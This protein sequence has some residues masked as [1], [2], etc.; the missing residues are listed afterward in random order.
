MQCDILAG[1]LKHRATS[2]SNHFLLPYENPAAR[3]E[4]DD[5]PHDLLQGHKFKHIYSARLA[6]KALA[7]DT[8]L[9]CFPQFRNEFFKHSHRYL[10]RLLPR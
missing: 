1:R 5:P 7:P 9:P 8:S 4:V 2:T 10:D 3:Y 6:L